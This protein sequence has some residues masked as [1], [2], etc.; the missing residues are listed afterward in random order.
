[1]K[2]YI[3][4]IGSTWVLGL[5]DSELSEVFVSAITSVEIIAAIARRSRSGSI[6]VDDAAAACI[7]WQ[8]QSQSAIRSWSGE[9]KGVL[10][11]LKSKT[12]VLLEAVISLQNS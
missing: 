7:H 9:L 5:F 8:H 10:I 6:N 1:M 3:Q 2:R 12:A 4:E 11:T